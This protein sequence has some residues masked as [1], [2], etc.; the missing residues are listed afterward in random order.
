MKG[1]RKP[2]N[3]YC[4]S[5]IYDDQAAGN[6]RQQVTLCSVKTCSL[7][8][9]RPKSGSAIPENVKSYYGAEKGQE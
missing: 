2:I 8:E 3:D 9:V 4:K 1:L 7:Y 6:W 5:C